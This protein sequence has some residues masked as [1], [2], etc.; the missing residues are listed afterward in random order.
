MGLAAI[1][2][3]ACSASCSSVLP[4]DCTEIGCV[5]SVAAVIRTFDHS[6][7][8]GLYALT[9]RLD[10]VESTCP[11]PIG[12][13]PPNLQMATGCAPTVTY[14]AQQESVCQSSCDPD[15]CSN[16]CQPLPGKYALF[17][18]VQG[19]PVRVELVITRDG[20]PFAAADSSPAY[21]ESRPNG[22]GCEPLCRQARFEVEA[23]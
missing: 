22:P 15:H 13:A 23:Q 14:G 9:L 4:H 19:N 6:L 20:A 5:D 8:A 11:L 18:S 17:V 16:G 3:V 10:G 1:A 12:D 21:T 2:L 7:P